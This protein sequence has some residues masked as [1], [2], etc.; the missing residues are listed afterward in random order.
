[1]TLLEAGRELGGLARSKPRHG[2]IFNRGAHALYRGGAAQRVLSEL[3]VAMKGAPP[4]SKGVVFY[5]GRMHRLPMTPMQVMT[6][7]LLRWRGRV[8]LARMFSGLGSLQPGTLAD[9]SAEQWLEDHVPD[10]TARTFVGAMLRL[11]SYAGD[12]GAMS[13]DAALHQL[14]VAVQHGVLYLDGGWQTLVEGLTAA[15]VDA[16]VQVRTSTSVVEVSGRGVVTRSGERSSADAVVLAIPPGNVDRLLGREVQPRTPAEVACLDVGLSALPS[17]R[18]PSLAFDLEDRL[19]LSVHS[20]A[21]ALAPAGGAMIHVMQYAPTGESEQR[22][23]RLEQMLDRTYPGWRELR[24]VE[25]FFP[26][27]TVTHGIPTPGRGG[28]RGRPG[29]ADTGVPG[30]WQVGDWVGPEGMLADAAL[31]SASAAADA[32]VGSRADRRAA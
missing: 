13:A 29:P 11:S 15:C 30:V 21:A 9:V 8:D 32:I 25:Q 5:R 2:F 7:G 18:G 12:L 22:R 10:D 4:K 6:T 1:M 14:Q 17:P 31:G 16:G 23:Q 27:M 3:G 28:L 19:Y 24:V 20:R 26:G